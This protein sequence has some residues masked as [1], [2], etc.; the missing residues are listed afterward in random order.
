M[1]LPAKAGDGF[2]TARVGHRPAYRQAHHH[3][4]HERQSSRG[5]QRRDATYVQ[6]SGGDGC[7]ADAIRRTRFDARHAFHEAAFWMKS[8]RQRIRDLEVQLQLV[9]QELARVAARPAIPKAEPDG[10]WLAVLNTSLA[11]GGTATA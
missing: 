5:Q 4:W 1:V 10:C 9:Q 6:P 11:Q 2:R 7:R 3:D 8:D